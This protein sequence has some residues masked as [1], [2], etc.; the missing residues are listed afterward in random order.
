MISFSPWWAERAVLRCGRQLVLCSDPLVGLYTIRIMILAELPV[1][2]FL[3]TTSSVYD[4]V[5]TFRYRNTCE[6]SI[7]QLCHRNS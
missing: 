4:V 3:G 1:S 7:S 6:T 2:E 5:Y